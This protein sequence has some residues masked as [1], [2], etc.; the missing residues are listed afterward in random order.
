MVRGLCN[1]FEVGK[2]IY[3]SAQCE[4]QWIGQRYREN[5]VD[6]TEF[7]M[8]FKYQNIYLLPNERQFAHTV[9]KQL[10]VVV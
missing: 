6:F 3:I 8:F 7:I 4:V 1:F 10:L 5:F 9:T 2:R